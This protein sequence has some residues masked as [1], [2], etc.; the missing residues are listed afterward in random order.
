MAAWAAASQ[1]TFDSA[2]LAREPLPV[3]KPVDVVLARARGGESDDAG[4]GA[5]VHDARVLDASSVRPDRHHTAANRWPLVA[6]PGQLGEDEVGGGV[7]TQPGALRAPVTW[8][9]LVEEPGRCGEAR[10]EV[11]ADRR[12]HGDLGVGFLW[13]HDSLRW[14]RGTAPSQQQRGEKPVTLPGPGREIR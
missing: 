13:P 5:A 6:A 8:H 12:S 3:R 7:D 1:C 4:L 14:E 2:G 11:G 10:A 9:A